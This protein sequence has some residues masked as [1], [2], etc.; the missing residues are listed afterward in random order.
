MTITALNYFSFKNKIKL[1]DLKI[2]WK[3]FYLAGIIL[4]AL[5]IASC[6]FLVGELTRGT[7]LIE[8]YNKEIN[9]LV[10]KNRALKTQLAETEFFE[11]IAQRSENLNF[12]KTTEI[13]YVQVLDN[14]L[15]RA[16]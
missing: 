16:R 12:R 13:K 14:S 7:Y 15:A 6:V 9:I 5:M 2:N 8:R 3:S 4:F 11:R 1:A 10:E